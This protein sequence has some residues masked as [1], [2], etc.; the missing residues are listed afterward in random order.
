MNK[1][2][3]NRISAIRNRLEAIAE[4]VREIQQEEQEYRDAMPP[5]VADGEKGETAQS[6]IDAL[7]SAEES[8]GEATSSLEE[9]EA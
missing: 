7:A 9:A 8:I 1:D 5:G 6:A 3:R 2:R 4:E